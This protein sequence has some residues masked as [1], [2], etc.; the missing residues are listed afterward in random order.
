MKLFDDVVE[1]LQKYYLERDFDALL[2][3]ISVIQGELAIPHLQE[4]IITVP[5]YV[6]EVE[7][8]IKEH[9]CLRISSSEAESSGSIEVDRLVRVH[10]AED[11]GDCMILNVVHLD[12]SYI[13]L[14]P[15]GGAQ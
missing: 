4:S 2:D 6:S 15:G 1:C 8:L 5:L 3:A 12:D 14:V 11:A 7:E 13:I 9:G 10:S